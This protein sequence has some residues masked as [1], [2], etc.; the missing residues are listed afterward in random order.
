MQTTVIGSYPKPPYLN[1]PDWFQKHVDVTISTNEFLANTA[2]PNLENNI[3]RAIEEVIVEQKDLGISV[4]TDGEI[5]RENYIYSF[6][7]SLN[8]IDFENLT[9]KSVRTDADIINCPTITAKLSP[10]ENTFHSDEWAFS[11]TIAK[12]HNKLLKFTLPGPMTISDSLFNKFYKDEKQLC[13]DLAIL[14]R[15]E[16]LHLKEMGCTN[17]QIDEPLFARKPENALDWGID[18]IDMIVKDIEG[19]FFVCHM[20][21]GYPQYLDQTD[22]KKA[23]KSSYDIL[24]E[25]LDK[26]N[27]DAISIEDAHCHNQDLS[28]LQKI[29]SKKVV[30]WHNC[31]SK[32]QDRNGG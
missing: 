16:V 2:H 27:I 26:S 28:F 15:Q 18:L 19:V 12:K 25:R 10:K 23:P 11:N 17:I 1:L 31:N 3:N 7:R 20:C 14:L 21:C 5:T 13:T 29:K 9:A 4:I 6:C 8:G 32:K 24:V 30:F 22:Y